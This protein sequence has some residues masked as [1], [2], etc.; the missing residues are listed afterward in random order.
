MNNY[1]DFVA[2]TLASAKDGVAKA[3]EA[4]NKAFNNHDALQKAEP[5]QQ[6]VDAGHQLIDARTELRA[7][8]VAAEAFGLRPDQ[9]EIPLSDFAISAVVEDLEGAL[10]E[11]DQQE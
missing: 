1:R 7:A 8:V 9:S 3:E 2:S 11:M 10:A 5:M 6:V 4:W